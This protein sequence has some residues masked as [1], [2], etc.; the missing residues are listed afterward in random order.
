MATL[1]RQFTA[2]I[3]SGTAMDDPA[4]IPLD[5]PALVVE[6]ID[7][8]VPHGPAGLMGF[9]LSLGGQQAI[10][11]DVGEW[12]VWDGRADS[13]PISDYSTA[14]TWAVVG[15]NLGDYD[16]DV[17]VRFHITDQAAT[18]VP[19]TPAVTFGGTEPPSPGA[20]VITDSDLLA[21]ANG[22]GVGVGG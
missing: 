3:P 13:W 8:E 22:L 9:Y 19:T 6:S 17:T 14:G 11:W 18:N 20:S 16:H 10:P 5:I 12:I 7:L 15:Y 4:T 21:A 1:I 2:T